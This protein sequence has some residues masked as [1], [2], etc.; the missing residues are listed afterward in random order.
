MLR[1]IEKQFRHPAGFLGRIISKLMQRGNGNQYD[2]IIKKMDIKDN[3]NLFEIGYGH[4]LGIEKILSERD[5]L[6]SGIDF[7][8]LMNKEASKR[9]TKHISNGKVKLYHGNFL[10][11]ELNP[12]VYD[13]I[14]CLNVIYF[15]DKLEIPFSK[16]R[17]GLKEKGLFCFYMDHPDDLT[18]QGFMKEDLFTKYT[19]DQVLEKLKL[20]EFNEI[21]YEFDNKG[22]YV[23]CRK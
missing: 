12:N 6:I 21:G 19:I 18:R 15:W 16:I 10:E 7:S 20:S 1:A 5:C 3:E 11:Y 17:T 13:K 4:G 23:T 14:F 9:N 2:K 22:Y 8:V